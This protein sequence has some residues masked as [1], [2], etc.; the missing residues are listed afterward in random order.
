[1]PLVTSLKN[2]LVN[3]KEQHP[4]FQPTVAVIQLTSKAENDTVATSCIKY[5]L[6]QCGIT[7]DVVHISPASE[8]SSVINVIQKLN[9][10]PGVHGIIAELPD[11]YEV[12]A[13]I[14][15]TIS[16]CKDVAGMKQKHNENLIEVESFSSC[17]ASAVIAL[18]KNTELPLEN[19]NVF[20]LG[21]ERIVLPI[22]EILLS[23][24]AVVSVCRTAH[25]KVPAGVKDSDVTIVTSKSTNDLWKYV[26]SGAIIIN[27]VAASGGKLTQ[28]T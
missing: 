11:E 28:H 8:T 9:C 4:S 10:D 26:K 13:K 17:A 23:Q 19:A 7:A 2:E 24:N 20:V 16:P 6:N 15:D 22:S 18:I 5:V 14:L 21:K 27:C 3:L 12:S 1:M 25:E